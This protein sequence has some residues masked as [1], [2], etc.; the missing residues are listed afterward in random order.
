[1]SVFDLTD[2]VDGEQ[3]LRERRSGSRRTA[4][5]DVVEGLI[6]PGESWPEHITGRAAFVVSPA[7]IAALTHPVAAQ[8]GR[9][10]RMSDAL[11]PG[12]WVLLDQCPEARRHPIADA[13]YLVFR[14]GAGMIRYLAYETDTAY[15]I[16]DDV[17]LSPD[18]WETVEV[19]ALELPRLVRARVHRIV[20]SE[21][22]PR[23]WPAVQADRATATSR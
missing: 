14:N 23:K 21:Q 20:R 10:P 1:M 19:T 15:L 5:L 8:V 11:V 13:L 3:W 16:A 18:R 17:R 4:V 2:G 7:D 9:D 22:W 6:G 12:E